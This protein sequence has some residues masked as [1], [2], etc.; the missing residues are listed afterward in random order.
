ML[1]PVAIAIYFN[2]GGVMDNPVDG[3]YRH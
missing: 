1:S 2:D 3:G